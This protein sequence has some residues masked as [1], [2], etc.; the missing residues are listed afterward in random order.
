MSAPDRTVS[1]VLVV[2]FVKQCS[3]PLLSMFQFRS[4]SST[5]AE[6][7]WGAISSHMVYRA[8]QGAEG[9]LKQAATVRDLFLERWIFK[10]RSSICLG[11]VLD[12]RTELCRLSLQHRLLRPFYLV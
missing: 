10:N 4:P 7:I 11:T 12:S 3:V 9:G 1:I 2:V 5:S 6:D 8:Q